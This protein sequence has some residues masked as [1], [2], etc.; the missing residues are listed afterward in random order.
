MRGDRSARPWRRLLPAALALSAGLAA[1]GFPTQDRPAAVEVD[2]PN[3]L[4]TVPQGDRPSMETVSLWF[5]RDDGITAAS[6][7]VPTP[8]DVASVLGALAEGV[9]GAQAS[10]GLRSAIPSAD[11]IT[12]AS[13]DA[14]TANVDLAESFLDI[15]A[16][17]QVLALGQLVYTLTDLRGVGRVRFTIGEE[18][19]AVPLPNGD[20]TED[21]V[22]RDDF[23]QLA[24][25]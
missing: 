4:I 6:A 1:C 11:V 18:P 17:E 25:R 2:Q 7:R 12:D 3:S 8:A 24:R 20:S 5:V 10:R 19:V 22:S 13:L 21:S 15:P 23:A 9:T 16:G 14:G